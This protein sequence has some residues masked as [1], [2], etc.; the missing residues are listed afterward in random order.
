MAKE[1]KEEL[2]N[3][4]T[5][6]VNTEAIKEGKYRGHVI[7]VELH[8]RVIITKRGLHVTEFNT[9]GLGNVDESIKSAKEYI[10]DSLQ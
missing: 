1:Q 7:V 10:D 4:E 8:G 5:P 2:Q 6:D 3:E 9:D